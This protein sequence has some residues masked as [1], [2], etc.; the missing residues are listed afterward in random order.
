MLDV[1]DNA[2]KEGGVLQQK[3][4]FGTFSQRWTIEKFK[5]FYLIRNLK[6]NLVATVK[7]R[8]IKEGANIV[9]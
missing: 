2:E 9:Q 7:G 6:S 3:D 5:D 1:D 4:W 8:K